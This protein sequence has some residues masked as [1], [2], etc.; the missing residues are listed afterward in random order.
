MIDRAIKEGI[1][2]ILL[3]I[4]IPRSRINAKIACAINFIIM[5]EVL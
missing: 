4:Q 2:N 1:I 5:H 3:V